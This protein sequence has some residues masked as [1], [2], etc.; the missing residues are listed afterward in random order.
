MSEPRHLTLRPEAEHRA[1]QA[2]REEQ[3]TPAWQAR[4]RRRA[5]I[6]GTMAQGVGAFGLRRT[7]YRGEAKTHLQHVATAAGLNVARLAAWFADRPLAPTRVS[8]FAALAA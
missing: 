5:G 6:E 4:Y 1:L 2:L 7:R 3:A 8:H